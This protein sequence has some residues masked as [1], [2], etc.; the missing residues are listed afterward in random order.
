MDA[1]S[2][3][4]RKR[5]DSSSN[6]NQRTTHEDEEELDEVEDIDSDSDTYE[7]DSRDHL[8]KRNTILVTDLPLPEYAAAVAKLQAIGLLVTH[9]DLPYNSSTRTMALDIPE[10]EVDD[11]MMALTA[12]WTGPG[13]ITIGRFCEAK[14][15]IKLA[16]HAPSKEVVAMVTAE[17]LA[18]YTGRR[19]MMFNH[20]QVVVSMVVPGT[21]AVT[22]EDTDLASRLCSLYKVVLF[23]K[24]LSVG[25]WK[26]NFRLTA[27]KVYVSSMLETTSRRGVVEFFRRK[28]GEIVD[29]HYGKLPD[30]RMAP[31]VTVQFNNSESMAKALAYSGMP[32]HVTL[33]N[34]IAAT[35][36]TLWR[37]QIARASMAKQSLSQRPKLKRKEKWT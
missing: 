20:R 35:A 31:W 2:N 24:E 29:H 14:G 7:D 1:P 8:A 32:P 4:K 26:D 34:T 22:L 25:V 21:W 12:K 15:Q 17:A 19:G 3:V 27:N 16:I 6:P 28:C 9:D 37:V 23:S 30:G 36:L 13:R 5:A 33:P 10:Q 11:T 18:E